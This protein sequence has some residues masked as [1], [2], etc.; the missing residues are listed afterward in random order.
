MAL[1]P[2][3]LEAH[4]RQRLLLDRAAVTL[5]TE[6]NVLVRNSQE[7]D[8]DHPDRKGRLQFHA[9]AQEAEAL[10]TSIRA[11]IS[12][13]QDWLARLSTEQ[14]D[15]EQQA[16]VVQ[17]FHR[18]WKREVTDKLEELKGKGTAIYQKEM[19]PTVRDEV[20]GLLQQA[21]A[22]IVAMQGVAAAYETALTAEIDA[23]SQAIDDP[24][25]AVYKRPSQPIT[26]NLP[27]EA[28]P[29]GITATPT[30]PADPQGTTTAPI[31]RDNPKRWDYGPDA[32]GRPVEV[33]LAG[34]NKPAEFITGDVDFGGE[35]LGLGVDGPTVSTGNELEA[36]LSDLLR[37]R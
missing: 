35:S 12:Q 2:R 18:T 33:L 30:T 16:S 10:S 23:L 9:F 6:A 22:D 25:A 1:D 31:L 17:G 4:E 11:Q 29:V 15:P 32:N 21:A 20:R 34:D 14:L 3:I 28:P 5:L 7:L 37:Q 26:A 36:S 13:Q 27:Q 24:F 8:V 19:T